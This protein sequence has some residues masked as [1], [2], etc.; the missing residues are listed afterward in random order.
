MRN[1]NWN[2]VSFI[3]HLRLPRS[4]WIMSFRRR[5]FFFR[6]TENTSAVLIIVPFLQLESF[7][8]KLGDCK[9]RVFLF[10]SYDYRPCDFNHIRIRIPTARILWGGD[11]SCLVRNSYSYTRVRARRPNNRSR[12]SILFYQMSPSSVCRNTATNIRP[13]G[14]D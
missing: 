9:R 11:P 4:R 2:K 12:S 7:E 5:L 1:P 3:A 13:C 8:F 6:H 14:H 10:A